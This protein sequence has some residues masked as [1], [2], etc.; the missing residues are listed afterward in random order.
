MLAD[1]G[2]D[3]VREVE[4]RGALG[5]RLDVALGREHVHLVREEVDPHRV[6]ELARVLRVLLRLDQLAQPHER[7][8]ELVLARLARLALL[9]EPVGRDPFLG[10]TVHLAGADLDLHRVALGPD[11]RRVERL[12]H[13]DLRHR[14]EV[15]EA[16]GHR[17]PERVDHAQGAV[18]VTHRR[19]DDADGR[20]V[21]DLVELAALVVHLLPDRVE[22]LGPAADLRV[23]PDLGQLAL[24]DRDH[25]IDVGLALE[26]ALGDALLEVDVVARVERAERQVL[27]LGLH[28]GHAEPVRQRRV[29]VERLLRD[30]L[31]PVGRQIVERAHVVQTVGELDH[32]HAQVARHR[33]QHLPEV[34]GL[35]LFTRRER[36]LADLGDAVDQLGDLAAELTLEVGLGGGRVLQHVVQEP[37]GHRGDVHLE[38]DQEVGDLQ[39]MAEIWLAGGPLLTLM[40]GGRES[41][42][43]RED[44][45]ISPRL[46]LRN[47]LDQRF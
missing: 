2:V 38:V 17:L 13:V 28:L 25:L 31:G 10:D 8:V 37:G 26:A 15:L 4:R 16:P 41:V 9:V 12:V 21:V 23:D 47:L 45:E 35:A 42:S 32:E 44:V 39:R 19:G 34:L 36:E 29:D 6:H 14:N 46:V 7:L 5:Q 1:L 27:Q 24:E 11:H 22:V 3:R 18:A 30:L 20:Q 33:D 43:A 40:R